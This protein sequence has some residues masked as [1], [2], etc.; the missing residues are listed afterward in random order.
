MRLPIYQG[1]LDTPHPQQ[2]EKL[3]QNDV[4]INYVYLDENGLGS[5]IDHMKLDEKGKFINKWRHGFFNER[6]NEL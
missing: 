3:H 5:K 6:L 4:E 2:D 1:N